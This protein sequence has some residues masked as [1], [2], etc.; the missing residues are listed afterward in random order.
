MQPE[1]SFCEIVTNVCVFEVPS[2]GIWANYHAQS[3]QCVGAPG[4]GAG[5][6]SQADQDTAFGNHPSHCRH[7]QDGRATR[8]GDN[9]LGEFRV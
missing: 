6:N 8:N 1:W 2:E 4:Q 5:E 7:D 3:P 9:L